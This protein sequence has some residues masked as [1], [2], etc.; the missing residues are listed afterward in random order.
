[1]INYHYKNRYDKFIT[2]IKN[3]NRNLT[4]YTEK[5]HIIPK[6]LN[7]SDEPDNLIT[8]TLREHHLAHWLLWKAY[9]EN[10]SLESAFLQMC[11]KNTNKEG[12]KPIPSRVYETLKSSFYNWFKTQNV[13]KVYLKD[14]SGNVIVMSKQ[15]YK[16]QDDI[17]FH[18]SGRVVVYDKQS[19]KHVSIFKE[20]YYNNKDRYIPNVGPGIGGGEI[21]PFK[22]T[23]RFIN[24]ETNEVIKITKSEAKKLN[25]EAGY[26]KYKQLIEH[27]IKCIDDTGETV[28]VS[29]EEYRTGKYIHCNANTVKVY[30]TISK[31]T[32]IIDRKEYLDDPKR[33]ITSTKGKVLVK[34]N[35]GKS[36]LITKQE[37]NNGN[38]S[39]HTQGLRTVY[40][41]LTGKYVQLTEEE[42]NNNRDRYTGPN[43]GKIN[44]IDK[45]TGIRQQI[46]KDKFDPNIHLSL[47]SHSYM[48]RAK[49]ILTGKEKNINIYEW[50][51]VKNEYEIIDIEKFIKASSLK[52]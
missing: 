9:P 16:Q 23:Y 14:D 5:H 22:S 7:G 41:T 30:D 3:S 2:S 43:K 6:C 10:R 48:F 39:G 44:V 51:L 13:D 40:D 19:K 11:N 35:D 33:Y 38:Y 17:K 28:W 36:K 12:F 26:K 32:R 52:K 15:R 49:N 47:G 18:T 29:K 1:M 50:E 4:S 25:K 37:F 8:L 24:V 45:N 31:Q 20:D 42:W 46:E 27:K 21:N 34:D